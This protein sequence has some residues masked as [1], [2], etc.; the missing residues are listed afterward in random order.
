VN[1]RLGQASGVDFRDDL[2]V[3]NERATSGELAGQLGDELAQLLR[4]DAELAMAE[5]MPEVR[6]TATEVGV[7]AAG[8][9]ATLFTLAAASWAAGF[10][11]ATAIP[12]WSSALVVAGAWLLVA[13]LLLRHE[14]SRRL[15]SRLSVERQAALISSAS[16]ER[17]QAEQTLRRT[18]EQLAEALLREAEVR[19]MGAAASAARRGVDEAEREA[20]QLLNQLADV[21]REPGKAGASFLDWLKGV[22]GDPG[23]PA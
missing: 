13:F 3:L 9:I 17:D 6:R 8:L 15:V 21:L 23:P 2:R 11:L 10:G 4:C 12:A 7:L 14:Y 16:A 20:G 18:A 22:E 19:A 1:G 5:R